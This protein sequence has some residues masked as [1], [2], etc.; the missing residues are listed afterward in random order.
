MSFVDALGIGGFL[1]AVIGVGLGRPG[2]GRNPTTLGVVVF[3]SGIATAI[4]ALV[5]KIAF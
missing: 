5:W 2:Q 3:V 4:G 1:V